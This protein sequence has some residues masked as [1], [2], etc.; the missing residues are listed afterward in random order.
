MMELCSAEGA[1]VR[2]I[3]GG[4]A[5]IW[6]AR[7]PGAMRLGSWRTQTKAAIWAARENGLT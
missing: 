1:R 6:R 2:R 5:G 3:P 4:Q 7:S